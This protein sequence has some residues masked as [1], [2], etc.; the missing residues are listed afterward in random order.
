MLLLPTFLVVLFSFTAKEITG[1]IILYNRVPKAGSTYVIRALEG[2]IQLNPQAHI[3]LNWGMRK[4]RLHDYR[5]FQKNGLNRIETV[6]EPFLNNL[7]A[8]NITDAVWINIVRDPVE[9]AM[10]AYYYSVDIQT[11][12]YSLA[13]KEYNKRKSEGCGCSEVEFE[14][15]VEMALVSKHKFCMEKYLNLPSQMSYFCSPEEDCTVEVAIGH[16]MRDYLF[17]G[18][19][20]HISKAAK[21]WGK[22]IPLLANLSY[23]MENKMNQSFKRVTSVRNNLTHTRRPGALSSETRKALIALTQANKDEMKFFQSV[24]EWMWWKYFQD[25]PLSDIL[26]STPLPRRGG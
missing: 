20:D 13:M 24:T 19:N 7:A 17:V 21:V 4:R 22:H 5:H 12:V 2:V 3:E 15:C 8:A 18:L 23:V 14:D 10:S 11:R 1:S 9:L 26:S 25:F 6:H 16:V